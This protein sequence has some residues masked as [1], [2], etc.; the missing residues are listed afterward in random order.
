MF[1]IDAI[2]ATIEAQTCSEHQQHPVLT[3]VDEGVSIATCCQPFHAQMSSM[4]EKEIEASI[5]K[6]MEDALKNLE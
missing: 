3:V 6:L 5:Q 1:N 2:K 4:L